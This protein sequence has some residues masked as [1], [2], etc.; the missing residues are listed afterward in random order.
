MKPKTRKSIIKRFKI[1][2]SGKILR[3]PMGQNH[4]RSKKSG[5]LIRKKRKWLELSKEEAKVIKKYLFYSK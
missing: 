2:K 5:N 3:R 1:T 4:F